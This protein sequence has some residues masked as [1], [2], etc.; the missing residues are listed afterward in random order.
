MAVDKLRRSNKRVE[1]FAFYS[2]ERSGRKKQQ[3]VLDTMVVFLYLF[4][5]FDI[6]GMCI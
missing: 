6:C 5:V 4:C 1:I 2:F 3:S